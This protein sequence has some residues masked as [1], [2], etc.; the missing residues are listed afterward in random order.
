M[1]NFLS[2]LRSI[3]GPS[4]WLFGALALGFQIFYVRLADDPN[5]GFQLYAASW[6]MSLLS[7]L[8]VIKA[9]RLLQRREG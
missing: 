3:K 6:C 2:L 4:L 7:A 8:S 1:I 5:A 9:L